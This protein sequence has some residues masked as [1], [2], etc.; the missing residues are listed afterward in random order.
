MGGEDKFSEQEYN[1][2][3]KGRITAELFLFKSRY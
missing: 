3:S 2:E 1:E